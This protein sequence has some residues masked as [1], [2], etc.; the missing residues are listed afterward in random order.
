VGLRAV[1]LQGDVA[2]GLSYQSKNIQ[3]K[4]NQLFYPPPFKIDPFLDLSLNF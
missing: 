2:G 3:N 1:D 4:R